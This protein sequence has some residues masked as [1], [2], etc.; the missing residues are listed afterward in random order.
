MRTALLA[1]PIFLALAPGRAFALPDDDGPY[2]ASSELDTLQVGPS[3]V[4]ATVCI[5]AAPG[6][7]PLIALATNS[8][9]SRD[10]LAQW[11]LHLATYGFIAAVPDLGFTNTD[12]S[13][14]GTTLL[15]TLAF[16][17]RE[18]SRT[19]SRFEGRVDLAHRAVLGFN[20]GATGAIFAAAND[21]TLSAAILLDPE[22]LTGQARNAAPQIRHVPVLVLNADANACN[23]NDSANALYAALTGPRATLHVIQASDCDGEWP[24]S[25]TCQ[26]ACGLSHSFAAKYF[27]RFGTA[28]AA[29]FAGCEGAMRAYVDGSA[30]EEALTDR[31]IDHVDAQQ[32][33][34]SCGPYASLDAGAPN[35]GAPGPSGC[36]SEGSAPFDLFAFAAGV[37]AFGFSNRRR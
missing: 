22:D 1:L 16:F 23:G 6:P 26:G 12:A 25:T 17:E 35:A 37:L 21:D 19:G 9:E 7:R 31:T 36:G 34:E 13:S 32:L 2:S 30:V 28:Y 29:Y 8:T 18:N 5:P 3:Q 20:T 4:Q 33:P 14:I 15:D 24:A 10:V 11:C 27:R